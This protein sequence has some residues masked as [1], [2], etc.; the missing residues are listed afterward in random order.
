MQQD[1]LCKEEMSQYEN[2]DVKL[3]SNPDVMGNDKV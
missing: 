3:Q 2:T 1:A